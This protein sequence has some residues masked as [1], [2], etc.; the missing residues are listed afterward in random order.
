M[1]GGRPISGRFRHDPQQGQRAIRRAAFLRA[2]FPNSKDF[3]MPVRRVT[4]MP[5]RLSGTVGKSAINRPHDVALVQALLGEVKERGRPLFK[6]QV[7]GRFDRDTEVALATLFKA[8]ND[9]SPN[10][11][12]ATGHPLLQKISQNHSLTVVEGTAAPYSMDRTARRP[13]IATRDQLIYSESEFNNLVGI[14]Q[15]L[16][17]EFGINFNIVIAQSP[18]DPEIVVAYFHPIGCSVHSGTRWC[19]NISSVDQ[20]RAANRQLHSILANAIQIR[21]SRA[22][23]VTDP[24]SVA[25]NESIKDSFGA[26]IS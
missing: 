4:S 22:F 9:R 18:S 17:K 20:L 10:Q 1:C 16:A 8:A 24:A 13:A 23:E 26:I 5:P 19:R 12:L 7:S 6:G 11:R 14:A 25:V 2:H 21:T 3:P 15:S